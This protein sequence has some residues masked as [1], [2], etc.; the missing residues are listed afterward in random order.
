MQRYIKN[1]EK[2]NFLTK[3]N[4]QE[5]CTEKI[6]LQFFGNHNILNFLY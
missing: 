5:V 2:T 4:K 6:S 3:I 1:R